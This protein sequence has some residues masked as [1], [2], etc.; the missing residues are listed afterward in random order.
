M[1]LRRAKAISCAI[2]GPPPVR[3]PPRP[4][5]ACSIS[6]RP[7]A[8]LHPS[9]S[10]PTR[11]AAGTATSV[12]N[13]SQ[14][15]D[16]PLICLIRRISN[17]GLRRFTMST[18]IPLCLGTSHRVRTG[19]SAKSD[20]CAP[21]LQ[22]FWPL[23]IYVSPSRVALVSS[24]A[25][26]DPPLGSD[27]NCSHLSF[28]ERMFGMWASFCSWSPNAANVAPRILMDTPKVRRGS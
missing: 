27:R 17:P 18:E 9:F 20:R 19:Q 15:S 11:L 8:T 21:V 6:K 22:V 1:P 26:S 13:S 24:P 23:T 4:T 25:R 16:P 12:K 3:A 28:P 7:R 5:H 14:N 10:A 2:T